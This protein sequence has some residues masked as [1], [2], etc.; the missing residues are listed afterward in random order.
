MLPLSSSL[1]A[2]GHASG[3]C[4]LE[5][6]RR[7]GNMDSTRHLYSRKISAHNERTIILAVIFGVIGS[8]ALLFTI[9]YIGRRYLSRQNRPSTDLI[10][11]RPIETSSPP[12]HGFPPSP[13][14]TVPS[15]AQ[16]YEL[17]P[18]VDATPSFVIDHPYA[19]PFTGRNSTAM[20][21]PQPNSV[22]T[23]STTDSSSV[24]PN[25]IQSMPH[26]YSSQQHQILR[27][28]N[29]ENSDYLRPTYNNNNTQPR[30][31]TTLTP[32]DENQQYESFMTPETPRSV[33]SKEQGSSLPGPET[34]GSG[35]NT[36]GAT[37]SGG[38]TTIE[39]RK[40]TKI[41]GPAAATTST[42]MPIS[43]SSAYS[44]DTFPSMYS[45][46]STSGPIPIQELPSPHPLLEPHSQFR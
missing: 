24:G 29:A 21:N 6:D 14:A 17:A 39:R 25:S 33:T 4:F 28:E 8:I 35:I 19:H 11:E 42:L 34:L 40:E 36:T 31:T 1:E 30:F 5:L 7:D 10:I 45:Y 44:D 13:R 38:S 9:Y 16:P 32:P 43:P 12:K 18:T 41:D 3:S 27:R 26:P 23:A 37:G 15:L 46:T 2:S 22:R 20:L